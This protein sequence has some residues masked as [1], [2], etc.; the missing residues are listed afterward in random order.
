MLDYLVEKDHEA[1]SLVDLLSC[2][3]DAIHSVLLALKSRMVKTRDAY[4]RKRVLMAYGLFVELMARQMESG[5][6]G[7]RPYLVRNA[8]VTLV[9]ILKYSY[10]G[11]NKMDAS[12]VGESFMSLCC[13]ILF[14][15]CTA[16][17]ETCSQVCSCCGHVLEQLFTVCHCLNSC[18]F[19]SVSLATLATLAPPYYPHH[20]REFPAL[21]IQ[22]LY[23]N[24]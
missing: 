8:V 6:G 5:L 17:I 9:N 10:D 16:A 22:E 24:T 15:V 3:R 2:Q 19:S 23:L 1:V 14:T 18:L 7:S 12:V 11:D 21:L 13:G 20:S 4:E